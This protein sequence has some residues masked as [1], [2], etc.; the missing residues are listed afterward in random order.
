MEFIQLFIKHLESKGLTRTGRLVRLLCSGERT[1]LVGPGW[2][3][4][5]GIY[6]RREKIGVKNKKK[7]QKVNRVEERRGIEVQQSSKCSV[8]EEA[9]EC[10]R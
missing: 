3:S 7:L 1:Q 4:G 10:G 5:D 8:E 6:N 2:D 9:G